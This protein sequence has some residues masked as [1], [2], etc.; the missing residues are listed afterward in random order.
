MSNQ[1]QQDTTDIVGACTSGIHPETRE[2]IQLRW[3]GRIRWA[4]LVSLAVI[5][6][7]ANYA[8]SL[9]LPQVTL[10]EILTVGVASNV[11]LSFIREPSQLGYNLV[12]G[13]AIVLDVLLLSGLLYFCGGY[14]NP[15]SMMFM[16]YVTLAAVVLDSRWTWMVF[17]VSLICFFALFFFHVPL[18]QL[19]MHAHHHH[20]GH[21]GFSLHLHGMLVAFVMIG[22][23]VAAFVT[24]MNREMVEQG[25]R[26]AELQRVEEERRRLISLATLTAGAAHELA[27]PIATLA[28]INE[29]LSQALHDDPRW[30]E[31]VQTMQQ[32][33]ARCAAILH[34]MR[35]GGADLDGE[36]PKHFT[37]GEVIGELRDEFANDA[38]KRVSFDEACSASVTLYSLKGALLGALRALI[39]NG[40]QASSP[41]TTVVCHTEL[42][43]D[44]V[45]FSIKDSGS[46]MSEEVQSRAGEPFFTSKEPGKGMGLGLYLTKLF[47]LQVGGHVKI[48]SKVGHGTQVVLQVP[49]AMRV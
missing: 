19:G 14:T 39:K 37:L 43:G 3:L 25:E 16:A 49:K 47:A 21:E 8:L 18:P 28:L 26:I 9:E 24:R 41:D 20:A 7:G 12:A 32:E 2:V 13:G 22:G 38:S 34:K 10:G 27:T 44:E 31:D 23:I 35:S 6:F 30:S 4:A 29:D 17:A 33:L 45:L 11:A 40:L 5:F 42:I 46:G 48:F 1:I 36:P 15:F